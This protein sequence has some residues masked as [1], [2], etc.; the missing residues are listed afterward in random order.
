MTIP[1]DPP[2]PRISYSQPQPLTAH[3][4]PLRPP[5]NLWPSHVISFQLHTSPI[6]RPDNQHTNYISMMAGYY[7]RKHLSRTP[8]TN[9][10]KGPPVWNDS[11]HY[12]RSILLRRLL[13]SLLSLKPSPNPR[14]RRMLTPYRHYPPKSPRGPSPQHICPSSLRSIHYLSPP[15]PYRRQP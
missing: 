7:P 9:R 14:A 13:L 1:N 15:Q 8:Y 6:P 12:L 5:P 10:T 4:S 3:R 11:I 2:N